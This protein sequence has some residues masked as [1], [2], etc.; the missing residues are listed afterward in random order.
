[1]PGIYNN[2]CYVEVGPR[3]G[4]ESPQL[5]IFQNATEDDDGLYYA[6]DITRDDNNT[7]YVLDR[8]GDDPGPYTY[9]IKGFTYTISPP[10]TT[11]LGHFGTRDDWDLTPKRIEGSDFNGQI[12]VLHTDDEQ[13]TAMISI[14]TEDEVPW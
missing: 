11:P 3:F 9:V 6:E 7:M 12:A 10:A 5:S 13:A 2:N 4:T 1:M 8:L 14:F